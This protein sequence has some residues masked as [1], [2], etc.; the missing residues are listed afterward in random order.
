MAAWAH[1]RL[2]NFDAIAGKSSNGQ[3]V[4]QIQN[5]QQLAL[6]QNR[7]TQQAFGL[8]PPDVWVSHQSSILSGIED[9]GGFQGALDRVD[10]GERQCLAVSKAALVATSTVDRPQPLLLPIADLLSATA[11]YRHRLPHFPARS[12]AT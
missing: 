2:S 7:Y 4:F 3:I 8:L 6:M 11:T 9:D 1:S 12:P 10:Q 5:T